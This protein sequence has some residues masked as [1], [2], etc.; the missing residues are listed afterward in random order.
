MVKW[1][2][3]RNILAGLILLLAALLTVY[4]AERLLSGPAEQ[5]VDLIRPEADL[6]MQT[7]HYTETRNGERVWSVQAD[8]AEHDLTS[9]QARV[10]T[11]RMVVYDKRNGDIRISAQ[12]G[13]LDLE[14]RQ[15]RLRGKVVVETGKGQRLLADD[16]LF[17]DAER[18]VSTDGPVVVVGP[19]FEVS[20]VGLHYVID[21]RRLTLRDQ[22]EA[23]FSG[24]IAVP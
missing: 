22:V 3:A 18:T 17:V 19:E 1:F 21:S 11:I 7:I 5:V 8:S 16:L 12:Q 13:D 9:G 24:R 6:T 14:R 4:T 20:G 10:E 15:V 2:S 23:K